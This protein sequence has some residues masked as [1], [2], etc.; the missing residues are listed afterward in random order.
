LSKFL[1]GSKNASKYGVTAH[2][3]DSKTQYKEGTK[4]ILTSNN[5]YTKATQDAAANPTKYTDPRETAQREPDNYNCHT[6]AID[7]AK[8]QTFH[9]AGVMDVDDRNSKL[10]KNFNNVNPSEAIFGE[11]VITF[12]DMHTVNYFGASSDGTTYVFSKDG[13]N[14]APEITPILNLVGGQKGDNDNNANFGPVGNPSNLGGKHAFQF[15]YPGERATRTGAYI[16]SLGSG[17]FN[18]K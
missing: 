16:G 13:P 14:V 5:P 1:G 2:Q 15:D 8:G 3:L 10:S 18:P 7:G 17:Y 6:A 9:D 12:G 11:T 4:L